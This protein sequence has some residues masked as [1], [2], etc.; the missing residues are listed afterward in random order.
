MAVIRGFLQICKVAAET[1]GKEKALINQGFNCLTYGGGGRNRTGVDGFASRCITILLLR[2]GYLNKDIFFILKI[3]SG[4]GDS[5][6]RHLPWQ[7][8]ALPTELFPH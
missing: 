1:L 6:S 2:H 7:G 4:K 5:N 8:S 3:W